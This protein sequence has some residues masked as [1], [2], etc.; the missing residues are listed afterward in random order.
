MIEETSLVFIFVSFTLILGVAGE[1]FFKKTNIPDVLFLLILGLL[2]GPVLNIFSHE[3]L[4]PIIPYF[5]AIALIFILFDG[6]LNLDLIKVLKGAPRATLLAIL[7][8]FLNVIFASAFFRLLLGFGWLD[9]LLLSA[10]IGGSS[11]IIVV[12]LSA[13]LPIN[14]ETRAM[15]NLESALTD[16]LCTVSALAIIPFVASHMFNIEILV[17]NVVRS[18]II[19]FGFGVIFG[20]A[21][22]FALSRLTERVYLLTLSILL[23]LFV[24]TRYFGGAGVL[25]ALFFGLILGNGKYLFKA[26]GRAPKGKPAYSRV[27]GLHAEIVFFIRTFFFVFMGLVAT[28]T[29]LQLIFFSALLCLL[30]LATRF[31]AAKIAMVKSK[32]S[33]DFKVVAGMLPRGLAAAALSTLPM[34]YNLPNSELFPQ[35]TSMVIFGTVILSTL[36]LAGSRVKALPQGGGKVAPPRR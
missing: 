11:S 17:L 22:L 24:L 1:K 29:N 32:L 25:S 35:I 6:G 36:L 34:S 27:R 15:L 21:W 10:I 33:G 2:L 3:R 26:L 14:E 19:G 20:I 13:S 18:L 8:F 9:G 16:V 23:L 30:L 12:A 7:G 31:V 28:L 5:S 4:L